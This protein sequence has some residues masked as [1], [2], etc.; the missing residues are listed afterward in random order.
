VFGQGAGE[1]DQFD[2]EVLRGPAQQVERLVGGQALPGHE[3]A[4]GL[5]DDVAGS[6]AAASTVAVGLAEPTA[7]RQRTPPAPQWGDG[8]RRCPHRRWRR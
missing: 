8:R 3:D 4:L 6:P 1:V 2:V 7:M 5:A